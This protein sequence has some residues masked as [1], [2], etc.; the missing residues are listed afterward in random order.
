[1][2]TN[3]KQQEREVG[4]LVT[5]GPEQDDRE[6]LVA[7]RADHRSGGNLTDALLR[8]VRP[9][10]VWIVPII[11]T[12]AGIV[13]LVRELRERGDEIT[14]TFDS[15][16]G[17]EPGRTEVRYKGVIVGRVLEVQLEPVQSSAP[18]RNPRTS[19]QSESKI[20][21]ERPSDQGKTSCWP[22]KG[23]DMQPQ[24]VRVT[25]RLNESGMGL[26]EKDPRFWLVQPRIDQAGVTGLRTV[27]SGNYIE[28][29]PDKQDRSPGAQKPPRKEFR[30]TLTPPTGQGIFY[31][32]TAKEFGSIASGSPVYFRGVRV[33]RVV[34]SRFG[35][36]GTDE[37][38]AKVFVEEAFEE[39]VHE[40]ARFWN[41]SGI[42]ISLAGSGVTVDT[43]SIISVLG[44][45]LAFENFDEEGS[46]KPQ[47]APAWKDFELYPTKRKALAGLD[48]K[49]RLSVKMVFSGGST[50]GPQRGASVEWLGV[51]VGT[52]QDTRLQLSS[53]ALEP[54]VH[55]QA[56]LYLDDLTRRQADSK[57]LFKR[58][59]KAGLRARLDTSLLTGQSHITLDMSRGASRVLKNLPEGELPTEEKTGSID[60]VIADVSGMPLRDIGK[61]VLLAVEAVKT[62][63]DKGDEVLPPKGKLEESLDKADGFFDEAK[64]VVSSARTDIIDPNARIHRQTLET[65]TEVQRAVMGLRRLV[66]Y[67]QQHPTSPLF[68]KPGE[69]AEA[70]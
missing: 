53:T 43:Q 27:I 1:M 14:I 3:L 13:L 26:L 61:E 50:R 40:S 18:S 46:R 68:G 24:E 21:A 31:C 7:G 38:V 16:E 4:N 49:T 29:V 48:R 15:A 41:A 36:D 70:P 33:G 67:L 69:E 5:R 57:E 10:A 11:A 17:L 60:D 66:E 9:S 2:S 59:V 65:L 30:G 44:G 63:A 55:V 52:V 23:P 22:D 35:T 39:L 45:G 54:Q 51:Q 28:V 20:G 8:R 56:D 34:D 58:L 19:D 62:L 37:L 12:I 32:L 25:V 42:D 6:P 64:K 47:I